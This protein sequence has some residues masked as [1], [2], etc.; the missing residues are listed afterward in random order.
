MNFGGLP[1]LSSLVYLGSYAALAG[2]AGLMPARLNRSAR[3]NATRAY[4]L[5]VP[6]ARRT[7]SQAPASFL[8]NP[9]RPRGQYRTKLCVKDVAAAKVVNPASG[10]RGSLQETFGTLPLEPLD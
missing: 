10:T 9:P 4:R 3:W 8:L 7:R 5:G 6:S 2:S 1:Q